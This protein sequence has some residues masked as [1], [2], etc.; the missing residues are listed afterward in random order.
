MLGADG[1]CVG[2]YGKYV[3]GGITECQ[4]AGPSYFTD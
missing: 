2:F 4:M 3:T 1:E